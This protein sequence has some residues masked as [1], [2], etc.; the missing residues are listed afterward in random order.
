MTTTDLSDWTDSLRRMVATPGTFATVF[1]NTSDDDLVGSL[2][3]GMAEAQMDGFFINPT[4]FSYDPDSGIVTPALTPP[5]ISLI[6]LYAGS[7]IIRAELMARNTTFR[8]KAG[9]VEFETQQGSNV[10]TTILK[11]LEQRKID[12]LK[13]FRNFGA[14]MAFSMAD[15]YFIKA[16][17]YYP[18]FDFSYSDD[19]DRAY[20]YHDPYGQV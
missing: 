18:G 11:D 13:L 9:P 20:D 16:T 5:Q 2:M 15:A 3:D 7:R 8:A 14:G 12:I 6:V 10:L 1:P 17:G 4:L 19:I